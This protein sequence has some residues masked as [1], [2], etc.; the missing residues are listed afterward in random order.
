VTTFVAV[1]LGALS[2]G[3]IGPLFGQLSAARAAAADLFGVID[4]VP[5]VNVEDEV[6]YRGPAPGEKIGS[7]LSI[8]FRGVTFAYPS[9]K[10]TVILDNFSMI[11]PQGKCVGVAGASGS[12][13]STL[14]ALI[15]R[16]YDVDKGEV[17]VNSVNVKQ[18]HLPTLRSLLGYVSQ[19]PV[20]FATTI[21]EN[22]TM[23]LPLG[24]A[25]KEEA[26]V[27]AATASNAHA[28]VTSL[29]SGY[30]TLAGTSTAASQLS[31][32]QR[33]RICIARALIRSPKA[34]LLDEATSALDT[35]SERVVQAALDSLTKSGEG[36]T[37]LVVAHRLSTLSQAHKIVVLQAGKIIEEGSPSELQAKGS[38]GVYRSMLDAQ[39]VSNETDPGS[40]EPPTSELSISSATTPNQTQA[41]PGSKVTPSEVTSS[42]LT[43]DSA[44]KVSGAEEGSPTSS[45]GVSLT[46]RLI[47]LQSMDWPF[48]ILGVLGAAASGCSQP[49]TSLIYGGMIAS[50]YLPDDEAL[51]RKS[52]EYLGW[53]FLLAGSVLMG[54]LCRVSVWT[55]VGERMTRR[56]R[57][58]C[59]ASVT[60][61]PA[62][63]FDK[64]ENSVGRIT[65]RLSTDCALVKGASGEALGSAIEGLTAIV[66][67]LAIAFNAS[68]KLA[69]V[70]LV[71]F[72][73]LVIGGWFEFRSIA[74]LSKGGNKELEDAGEL[75]SET[76]TAMRTVQIYGL[77]PR[78]Y[79]KFFEALQGPLRIGMR[80]AIVTGMGGG[81]Q[82][83]VL[84]ATYSV[85][86]YAGAQFISRGWLVF[87]DLIQV[88]L[89]ITLAAEALGRISSQAPDTAKAQAAA[90]ACFDLIDLGKASPINPLSS[91]GL[92]W[93]PSTSPDA[94]L[95]IAFEG[96]TFAYPTRPSLLVLNNFSA[97]IPAGQFVGVVGT[98]GSGKS[99][100]VL[101]ILRVYDVQKGR[102]L[103]GG[104]DVKEWN[105]AA[106]RAY[107]GLVQQE[108]ALFAD[109]VG[110][111]IGYGVKSPE[112]PGF[113]QGVQPK[114]SGDNEKTE[115]KEK[116]VEGAEK[117]KLEET[118]VAITE[119][120]KEYA[121][122]SSEVIAAAEAANCAGFISEFPNKYATYCGSR[123]SQLS[124]GQKQRVAIARS[125]LR[126]P[127]GLLLDEATAALDSKSE[128][129]VQSAL[130]AVISSGKRNRTTVCIAHRLSTLGNADRI[131]VI[132]K[133]VVVEEGSHSSL[134]S[135][136]GKYKALALAQQ[137]G[138]S[139]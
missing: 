115:D 93:P 74:Q 130:D 127:R 121:P 109:S 52:L 20:L 113:G 68:W 19:D 81:F 31:G 102:V 83:F 56:L 104:V 13:K 11:I 4:A 18:W 123:G 120:Q 114:E 21:R 118:A 41:E 116:G 40:K 28:F 86:F 137:A 2:F 70:L 26:V 48:V 105:V 82:R 36:K 77:Q 90:K 12:G 94:C 29:P 111:N 53:F 16:A 34:L 129:V 136:S 122:P 75:L 69:L 100:L 103:V 25:L 64:N 60:S 110:Y 89:A 35:T 95:D 72:P 50:Y 17:L 126:N 88:F 67:A 43:R 49:I 32:G 66:A 91:S 78:I 3:Q 117:K 61:Q 62:S 76:I 125:L 131:I 139:T 138:L 15:M 133:G 71:A 63:F 39:K 45:T 80:R 51:K 97:F 37:M 99:T 10:D 1:L 132:D 5:S 33:Q 79:A 108:P 6:G 124:G 119:E 8:E 134:M 22:I 23:G 87:G 27:E 30:D 107:F 106:L 42:S 46:S 98:S 14:C 47:E 112:K 54:V 7:G 135:L 59:F 58:A 44:E 9:R 55:Y 73:L 92:M 57:L 84:M 24:Q 101:L 38:G 85:S 128:G 96:V 65:T